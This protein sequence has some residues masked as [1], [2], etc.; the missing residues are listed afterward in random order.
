M[1]WIAH[2][3]DTVVP[4]LTKAV[5][6]GLSAFRS[7]RRKERHRYVLK[8]MSTEPGRLL[9]PIP[10]ATRYDLATIDRRLYIAEMEEALGEAP[11]FHEIPPEKLKQY[12]A[13]LKRL[14]KLG[15][16]IPNEPAR[17]TKL[18]RIL[19][20]MVDDNLLRWEPPNMWSVR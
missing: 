17:A 10:G 3:A 8:A 18:E 15:L 11:L 19:H 2:I 1:G 20:E 14:K 4:E 5:R 13:A 6:A 9:A 12:A 7:A 16:P